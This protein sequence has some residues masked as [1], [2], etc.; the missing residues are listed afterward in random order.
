MVVMKEAANKRP[1]REGEELMSGTRRDGSSRAMRVKR[2]CGTALLSAMV[3]V[4]LFVALEEHL[5]SENSAVLEDSTQSW[6]S[7]SRWESYVSHQTPSKVQAAPGVSHRPILPTCQTPSF[8][9]DCCR[10]LIRQVALARRPNRGRG[11]RR[12]SLRRQGARRSP[13]GRCRCCIWVL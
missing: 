3:L 5:P 4:L 9:V 8:L 6:S 12:E 11:R 13:Y 1:S 7:M 10:P 2:A